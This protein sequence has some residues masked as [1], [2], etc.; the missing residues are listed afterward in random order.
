[1]MV[2]SVGVQCQEASICW[3]CLAQ[4]FLVQ[5]GSGEGNNTPGES[6]LKQRHV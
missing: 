3:D 5:P 6:A 4:P 1:M 2:K